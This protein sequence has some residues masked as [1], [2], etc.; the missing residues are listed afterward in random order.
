MTSKN[1]EKEM[2]APNSITPIIKD[3]ESGNSILEPEK[4]KTFSF[5]SYE[6]E[7]LR[8]DARVTDVHRIFIDKF[9]EDGTFVLE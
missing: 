3:S 7:K 5:T 4:K 2:P 1:K 6:A 9:F 8:Q